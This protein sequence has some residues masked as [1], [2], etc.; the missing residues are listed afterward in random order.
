MIRG[1]AE[2]QLS[3]NAAPKLGVLPFCRAAGAGTGVVC[4]H[5]N[6][7]TSAQWRALMDSLSPLYR[8]FTPD[9][10]GAGKSPQWPRDRDVRLSDEVGLLEPVFAAAQSPFFL[11][12]HSYG[13]AVALIAALASPQRVRAVAV[14]EPTLFSLLEE[15]APGQDAANGIRCAAA[16]AAAAIEANR[17]AAAGERFI[18]YWMGEGAWSRMP[19]ARQQSIAAA[20]TNVRGW[21]AA[22]FRDP[23]P[24]AAFAKLS[25]PVL[26]MIGARSPASTRAVARLLTCTL[27]DVELREFPDLGHMG[28]VTHPD[29]VN[30]AIAEFIS[31][32]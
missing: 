31:R 4:I 13:A 24:L 28:P 23:T 19:E 10:L 20:M 14:Y 11:V 15:D 26:Y 30:A 17:H 6:A 8:V 3:G 7:S 27:P 18:D 29:R 1:N 2:A 5:S 9:S 32:N 21:A 12:G 25:V 16:D 22:L